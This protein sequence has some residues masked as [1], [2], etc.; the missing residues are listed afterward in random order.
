MYTNDTL[1]RLAT[2][3]GWIISSGS[4]LQSLLLLWLRLT[5]GHQFILAGLAKLSDIEQT[6]KYF[7]SLSIVYPEFLAYVVGSSEL[8]FGGL[9][10]IGL[11]SR[12][13]SIPLITIMIVALGTAHAAM[14]A[15]FQFITDPSRLVGEAPYPF[16]ITALLIFIF[17]PGRI[18]IDA[19]IHRWVSKQPTY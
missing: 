7:T 13:A 9:L 11:A 1:Q 15:N 19:L 16:L 6:T 14:L 10:F 8:F 3:Y 18:S 5:W 17:G 12:L 4:N 2:I